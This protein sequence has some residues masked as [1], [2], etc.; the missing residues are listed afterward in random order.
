MIH[1]I[2]TLSHEVIFL[3]P[4]I[5]LSQG[6]KKIPA[7]PRVIL[8]NDST[9]KEA[10]LAI[11]PAKM[12]QNL[13]PLPYPWQR[14]Q[15]LALY[16]VSHGKTYLFCGTKSKLT[17]E[18]HQH[19]FEFIFC[20]SS[21]SIMQSTC[22]LSLPHSCSCLSVSFVSIKNSI[23]LDLIEW[24]SRYRIPTTDRAPTITSIAGNKNLKK[25]NACKG[26]LEKRRGPWWLCQ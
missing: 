8:R 25:P 13:E 22:S 26:A 21:F 14:H 3:F 23:L 6:K 12:A 9:W 17:S 7:L 1:F 18:L 4:L 11:R 16:K 10:D 24:L 19:Q 20:P 15:S 5:R 2:Q